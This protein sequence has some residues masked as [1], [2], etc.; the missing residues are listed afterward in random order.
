AGS[1]ARGQAAVA[2]GRSG[3][4]CRRSGES[5][6]VAAATGAGAMAAGTKGDRGVGRA[7]TAGA[8]PVEFAAGGR[9][10]GTAVD[11]PCPRVV[12]PL[13]PGIPVAERTPGTCP[14]HGYDRW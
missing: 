2:A 7:R 10:V 4:R 12:A 9:R 1:L 5:R 11:E 13:P 8:F 3:V 6:R 14:D